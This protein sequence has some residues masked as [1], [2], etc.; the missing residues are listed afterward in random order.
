MPARDLHNNLREGMGSSI[1]SS[2]ATPEAGAK[3]AHVRAKLDMLSAS[4]RGNDPRAP[5]RKAWRKAWRAKER[6]RKARQ[7]ELIN[8]LFGEGK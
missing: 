3:L 2:G 5:Q 7:R 6:L 8:K 4:L 1:S